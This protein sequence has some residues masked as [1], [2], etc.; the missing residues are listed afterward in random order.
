MNRRIK[1]D[2]FAK[3]PRPPLPFFPSLRGKGN[4]TFSGTV[5]FITIFTIITLIGYLAACSGNENH[6]K[7]GPPAFCFGALPVIQA[8]PLFVA[9]EKG[10]FSEEGLKVDLVTFNSAMEK[11]VALSSGELAGYFGDMMTPMVLLANGT[12][13]RII[14]TNFNTGGS[15]RTF[16]VVAAPSRNGATLEKIV[17]EGIACSS[18]TLLDYLLTN[19]LE[20]GGL[21]PKMVNTIEI[22]KIPLRFQI[23]ITDQVPAA[24]LPE[25]LVT[26]AEI[27]G[28]HTVADDAALEIS[29]TILCFTEDFLKEHPD[30]VR[31]FTAAVNRAVRFI[32]ER[33]GD[34][35]SVMN[36]NCR[37]PEPLREKF[38]IPRFPE[39][40]LPR[41][42]LLMDVYSWLREKE[43][44][45]KDLAYEQ[46]VWDGKFF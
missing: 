45:T 31:S 9:A 44:I 42:D 21:D 10:F 6:P 13:L 34:V 23:L 25:P 46:I 37:I 33:P 20:A 38:E 14:A 2:D 8:L 4:P 12:P 17:K 5:K 22:K 32:N 19:I 41:R 39:L 18:N 27:K 28:A 26:L 36:S 3:S 15:R 1:L 30:A 43:I 7:E 24:I 40:K 11:D 16:A 35:R 29:S